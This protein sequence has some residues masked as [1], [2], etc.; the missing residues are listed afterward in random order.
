MSA[1]TGRLPLYPD[2][3]VRPGPLPQKKTATGRFS[4]FR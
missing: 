3:K 4:C 1:E 2:E